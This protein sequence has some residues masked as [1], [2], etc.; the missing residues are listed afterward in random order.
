MRVLFFLIFYFFALSFFGQMFTLS[1]KITDSKKNALP[2][3]SI[4]LKGTTIATNSNA[5][6]Y[7]NFKLKPGN[8]EIVFQ[9]VGYK[10][11]I[12]P[13]EVNGDVILNIGFKSDGLVPLAE[14]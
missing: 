6:G 3:A 2:F 1:G 8:Y 4:I 7:Y 9:Y 5:D 14:F 11:E 13:V 12:K 10:R